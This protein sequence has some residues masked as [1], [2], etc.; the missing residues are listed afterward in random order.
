MSGIGRAGAVVA[1]GTLV[2]RVT[3]LVRNIVLAAALGT[4]GA[5]AA[6]AFTLATQ[7]PNNIYAIISSGLLAGAA[8]PFARP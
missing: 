2:S 5:G 8:R 1:A 4:V 3:G 7:L 6:D